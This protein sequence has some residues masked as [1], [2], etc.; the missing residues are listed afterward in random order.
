MAGQPSDAAGTGARISAS[1]APQVGETKPV[2]VNSASESELAELPG[3]GAILAKK[4]VQHRE[5]NQGFR[6]VDEFFE[7][8]GLKPHAVVRLRPLLTCGPASDE[9]SSPPPPSGGGRVVDY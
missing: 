9:P 8:L 5:A 3:I 1:P 7:V 6:S 4:A 2:N